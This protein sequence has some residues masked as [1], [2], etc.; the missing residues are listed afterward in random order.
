[1]VDLSRRDLRDL[2]PHL[3][4]LP[5]DALNA[6]DNV[7]TL[8]LP[9]AWKLS[10]T[11]LNLL[12]VGDYRVLQAIYNANWWRQMGIPCLCLAL[13]VVL[14]MGAL[15]LWRVHRRAQVYLWY[16]A[17]L[18]LMACRTGYLIVGTMPGGPVWWRAVSDI[19]VLLL[20]FTLYRL[21]TLFW[22]ARFRRWILVW[23]IGSVLLQLHAVYSPWNLL[24]PMLATLFWLGALAV[25][26]TLLVQI[27]LD[28]Q[29]VPLVERRS[30]QCALLFTIGCSVLETV[31]YQL[32]PAQRLLWM[33]PV[34]T[35]TLAV[36]LAFL[37]VR[38]AT[39]GTT[40][41]GHATKA[42]G[43]RLDNALLPARRGSTSVW[44]DVTSSVA[45]DERQRMLDVI[46][47]GFGSRMVTALMRIHSEHPDSRLST[48]IQR[49]LLD[50]R[51]MI[52]AIDEPC[53]SIDGAL[54]TLRQRM[55]GPLAAADL[56]SHWDIAGTRNL[57]VNS[58]RK[59]VE[60][61]RCVEELLSNVIQHA[62]ASEVRVFAYS[63]DSMI[64][65]RVEDNGRGI[66]VEPQQGR[67]LRNLQTRIQALNGELGLGPREEGGGTRVE[68]RLPRF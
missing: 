56:H 10:E 11:R 38:R 4:S 19:T 60:L 7:L 53:Q 67:G 45:D 66:P 57:Q 33:Y 17:C 31:A 59:L 36:T 47:E 64:V 8:Q 41:L 5:P 43:K 28:V 48:E 42:L 30:L 44:E 32:D 6:G 14:G 50:L 20:V 13:F 24:F 49:A 27:M 34:G 15:T 1:G 25:A 21:L 3:H 26:L 63:D 51:L 2:A 55:E 54:A 52:D 16:L 61:F 37:L 12:C 9:I 46:D 68:L 62:E 39:M 29:H 65:L 22:A 18:V 58:R 35:A 23:L 40:L